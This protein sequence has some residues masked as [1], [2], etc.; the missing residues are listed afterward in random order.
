MESGNLEAEIAHLRDLGLAELRVLWTERLGTPPLFAS[1]ELTRRWL[2]WELQA[3]VRGGLD[4][5]TCRRL[6]HLVGSLPTG[7]TSAT[8]SHISAQPGTVLTREWG[9]GHP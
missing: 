4:A 3:A 2:A 8:S 7:A 6:R 5:S 1:T 9:G